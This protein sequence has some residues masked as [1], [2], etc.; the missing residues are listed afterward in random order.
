MRYRLVNVCDVSRK[1]MPLAMYEAE[2]LC[3]PPYVK[4]FAVF[5]GIALP[6][7]LTHN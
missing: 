1:K 4:T 2:P 7:W 6:P 3:V 5:N